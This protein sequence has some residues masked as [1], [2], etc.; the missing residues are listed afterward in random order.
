[1]KNAA[2]LSEKTGAESRDRYRSTWTGSRPAAAS[3]SSKRAA[4]AATERHQASTSSAG[5]PVVTQPWPNRA[6]RAIERGP[7]AATTNGTRGDCTQP[8]VAAGVDRRVV[9]AGAG[10]PIGA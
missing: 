7:L 5:R 3:A 2:L 1:M 4:I 6:A 10:D 9:L 8:G